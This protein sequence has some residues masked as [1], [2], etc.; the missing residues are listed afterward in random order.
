M[1]NPLL[2]VTFISIY[3]I[4][5]GIRMI[6]RKQEVIIGGNL[7]NEPSQIILKEKYAKAFAWLYL[8]GSVA[9]FLSTILFSPFLESSLRIYF[10]PTCLIGIIL[11]ITAFYIVYKYG[12]KGD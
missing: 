3:A 5:Y 4:F 2:L 11:W 12:A 9:I 6:V 7:I 1:F 10:V 8:L